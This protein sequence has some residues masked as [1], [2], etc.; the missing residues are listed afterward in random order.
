MSYL[1]QPFTLSLG[2][3]VP[4]QYA[5]HAP[6]RQGAQALEKK[7]C[8][9][10]FFFCLL[11]IWNWI[12]QTGKQKWKN[13][14]AASTVVRWQFNR[15]FFSF[16]YDLASKLH[17]SLPSVNEGVVQEGPLLSFLQDEVITLQNMLPCQGCQTCRKREVYISLSLLSSLPLHQS[18]FWHQKWFFFGVFFT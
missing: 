9:K 4:S 14:T 8:T 6:V 13:D 10:N 11:V 16:F 17:T 1:K 15:P 18:A 5:V 3:D 7:H 12:N 2:N